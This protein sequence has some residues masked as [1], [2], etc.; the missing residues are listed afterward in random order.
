MQ[1]ADFGLVADNPFLKRLSYQPNPT[2]D[3]PEIKEEEMKEEDMSFLH[4]REFH[5]M[6]S[7]SPQHQQS[8]LIS[9]KGRL[10][11]NPNKFAL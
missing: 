3:L 9:K 8:F 6:V 11:Y 1:D 4:N 10:S 2:Q 5:E 7:A